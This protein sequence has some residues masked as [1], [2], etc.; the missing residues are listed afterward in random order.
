MLEKN[1]DEKGMYQ[2]T[3]EQNV[4]T[5]LDFKEDGEGSGRGEGE[6]GRRVVGGRGKGRVGK[7]R[8]G[9]RRQRGK[10]R[11]G[12][13][14]REWRRRGG[15]GR[16]G[17]LPKPCDDPNNSL[18]RLVRMLGYGGVRLQTV[19]CTRWF[20]VNPKVCIHTHHITAYVYPI[21][22]IKVHVNYSK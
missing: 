15:D 22:L 5:Y 1:K 12:E 4:R 11:G 16:G 19:C 13:E 6:R 8:V 18:S 3:H 10:Q 20:T 17:A 9:R 7:G 21:S 2:C 14:R